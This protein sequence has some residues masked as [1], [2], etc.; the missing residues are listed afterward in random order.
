MEAG[1]FEDEA[2]EDAPHFTVKGSD[3]LLFVGIAM[4]IDHKTRLA[5]S[6]PCNR[7]VGRLLRAESL[8]WPVEQ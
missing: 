3:L 2:A 4:W 5:S 6:L 7:A 8:P 1:A